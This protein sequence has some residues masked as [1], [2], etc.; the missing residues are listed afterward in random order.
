M[1]AWIMI[2]TVV[3]FSGETSHISAR[4][5][6]VEQCTASGERVSNTLAVHVESTGFI[7]FKEHA[8]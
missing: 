4:F 3:G 1:L 5:A 8:K 2:L 7:C 6:S